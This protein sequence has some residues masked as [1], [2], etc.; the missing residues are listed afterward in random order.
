[1]KVTMRKGSKKGH[2]FKTSGGMKGKK[3]TK[4]VGAMKKGARKSKGY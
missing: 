3:S 4:Y 1:M 2:G